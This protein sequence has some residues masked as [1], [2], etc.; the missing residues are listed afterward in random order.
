MR[1][2]KQ[3]Y[4]LSGG[5]N[6]EDSKLLDLKFI[7]FFT[8]VRI[9][10]IPVAMP[11]NVITYESCFDWITKS[12][13]RIT[14]KEL[15]IDML[16]NLIGLDLQKLISYDAVYVGGGNAYKLLNDFYQSKFDLL[17]KQYLAQGGVYYGGSAGA[18]IAGKNIA[19]VIE[20]NDNNYNYENGLSIIGEFSVRCH[21]NKK[22]DANIIEYIKKY[23]N[24]VI[25][26]PEKTGLHCT[27]SY[28]EVIGY[29]SAFLFKSG[30]K[31]EMKINSLFGY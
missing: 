7:N 12:L 26:L 15:E 20:E 9:L 2:N 22:C 16:I 23:G 3:S 24:P 31:E 10:Y 13:T 28:C 4:F 29:E 17:L 27:S 1:K 19:T 8:G 5:G 6:E 14:S 18:I 30:K 25:A 11:Q 21:Y